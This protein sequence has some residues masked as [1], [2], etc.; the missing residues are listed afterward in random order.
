ME[1]KVTEL[2]ATEF[3][4]MGIK[5][6]LRAGL[7]NSG[8]LNRKGLPPETRENGGSAARGQAKYSS[9]AQLEWS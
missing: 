7:E 4:I 9:T 2:K 5:P 3:R 1:F 6:F 8:T